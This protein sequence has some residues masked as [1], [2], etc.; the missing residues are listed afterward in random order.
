[1][2]I[3]WGSAPDWVQAFGNVAVLAFAVETIRRERKRTTRLE[4]ENLSKKEEAKRDKVSGVSAWPEDWS[5]EDVHVVCRNDTAEPIYEVVVRG[6]VD[7]PVRMPSATEMCVR[8]IFLM[9]PGEQLDT[10]IRLDKTV[11]EKPYIDMAFRDANNIV[12]WRRADGYLVR[13]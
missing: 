11:I 1:M 8:S 7:L 2:L 10:E 13:A 5:S 12:W 4:D 9:K 6:A 3:D